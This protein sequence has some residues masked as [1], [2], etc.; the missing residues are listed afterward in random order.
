MSYERVT[1]KNRAVEKP[2]TYSI[3]HNEDD[4]VT[5]ARAPGEVYEAGTPVNAEN[6]NRMD[7]GIS[8]AHEAL[9]EKSS[10]AEM[11]K[12][13]RVAN[14]LVNSNFADP[15][16]W[17]GQTEYNGNH[18]RTIDGW[19]TDGA[20][21]KVVV[22]NGYVR[23]ETTIG[24]AYATIM[25]KVVYNTQYAGKTLT[26]AAYL[27]SNVTPR[28]QVYNGDTS[29]KSGEGVSGDYQVLV[30]SFT[31]PASTSD[32]ALIVKLQG[33]STGVGDYLEV[34]WAALYEGAY[35]AETLPA[36]V[37]PDKRIEMIR[38]GVPLNPP[39][40]LDNSWFVNPINQRGLTSFAGVGYFIDRW[41]SWAEDNH[42]NLNANGITVT[43]SL[44]QGIACD[45]TKTYTAAVCLA[46]GSIYVGTGIPENEDFGVWN[47]VWVTKTEYGVIF[48]LHA[49]SEQTYRWAALYEGAYTAETLPAYVYKGYAAELAECQR[50]YVN[51][52]NVWMACHKIRGWGAIVEI[53]AN[54]RVAPTVLIDST[55]GVC[56]Y[57]NASK[58]VPTTISYTQMNSK[59]VFIVLTDVDNTTFGES[60]LVKG[61]TGLSA[62]L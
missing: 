24:S 26:A 40:L 6:L 16:N 13:D 62:D 3:T 42:L 45:N 20:N 57:D 46:D 31:V 41:A 39:N 34:K 1:W 9:K 14:L 32:G 35:T 44:I 27:R 59:S 55:D 10:I 60:L 5:L 54:M 12:R 37:I 43:K 30:C 61:I 25:Q 4:T 22:S 51:T 36:Y 48:Y 23:A 52:A 21:K 28:I 18:A 53:P 15:L 11:H 29:I 58:W 33:K 8:E 38:C 19:G 56:I 17:R 50:Y 49:E 7:E 47:K 2:M